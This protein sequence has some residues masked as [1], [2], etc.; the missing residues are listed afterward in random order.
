MK[1]KG[2]MD[3]WGDSGFEG[4]N[5]SA[6]ILGNL[7]HTHPSSPRKTT[8]TKMRNWFLLALLSLAFVFVSGRSDVTTRDVLS[9]QA[10]NNTKGTDE[11]Q[12]DNY[13]LLLRGQ[14][15]FL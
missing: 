6:P 2:V 7:T 9:A 1:I 3:L 11:V 8:R 14:R 13:S 10:L 12:W 5:K 15:I 4:E